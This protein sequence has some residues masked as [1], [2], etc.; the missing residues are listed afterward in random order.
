MTVGKGIA[1]SKSIEEKINRKSG[2]K[3]EVMG[4]D[5]ALPQVLWTDCFT[6]AQD[7]SH[8]TTTHQDEKSV[9]PLEN[10]RRL[11]GNNRTKHINV[12]H[13]FIEDV[14]EQGEENMA[15]EHR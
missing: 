14:I 4:V 3:M 9:M 15:F 10:N 11:S 1:H 7:W 8:N 6:K 2:T 5:D 13:H 12:Q